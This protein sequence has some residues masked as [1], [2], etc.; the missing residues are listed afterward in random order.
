MYLNFYW[1]YQITQNGS[2]L[3]EQ[4]GIC[5]N[6]ILFEFLNIRLTLDNKHSKI[7]WIVKSFQ[8]SDKNRLNTDSQIQQ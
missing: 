6:K 7:K 5:T 3:F 8:K 1:R 4:Y 2:K